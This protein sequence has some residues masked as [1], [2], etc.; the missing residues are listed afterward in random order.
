[1][2]FNDQSCFNA[3]STL[4]CLL[5]YDKVTTSH[6]YI[7]LGFVVSQETQQF[8]INVVSTLTFGCKLKLSQGMFIEVT[9]T[10]SFLEFPM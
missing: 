6:E 4:M 7:T 1:M 5:S 3:D 8:R 2:N 10:L 9:S